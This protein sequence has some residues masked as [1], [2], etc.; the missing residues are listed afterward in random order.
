MGADARLYTNLRKQQYEEALSAAT[1]QYSEVMQE[2]PSHAEAI[3]NWG[4]ALHSLAETRERQEALALLQE[5]CGKLEQ[6]CA[7]SPSGMVSRNL[8]KA[9]ATGLWSDAQVRAGV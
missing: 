3:N 6:A 9:L 4:A 1:L 5:A 8:F 2:D 7:L